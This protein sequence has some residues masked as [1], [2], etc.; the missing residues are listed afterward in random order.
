VS[1]SQY[2]RNLFWGVMD[3]ECLGGASPQKLRMKRDEQVL[4]GR[5]YFT[6]YGSANDP[7][8][9]NVQPAL[10]CL[11]AWADGAVGVL[12]WQTI[13]GKN[14]L[15]KG[16]ATGLFIPHNGHIVPSVRLKAFRRG[17]QDVEY[18]TLLGDVCKQPHYA[19]AGGLRQR[20]D[21]AAKVHKAFELDAGTIRFAKASPTAMW[22]LRT[23]VGKL[24]SAKSP[25]YRRCIRPMPSPPA[26]ASRLPDVGYVRIAPK[27]PPS[28]PEMD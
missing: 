28:R 16:S 15:R 2:G 19:V 5:S 24:V 23:S 21:L 18:L 6:E 26:G 1:Y 9:A 20:I 4:W 3:L 14:N 10:W 13:G 22:Q 17:Q 25:P 12:P 8:A 27:L 11:K 7:A